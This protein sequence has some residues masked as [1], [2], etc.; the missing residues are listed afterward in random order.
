MSEEDAVVDPASASET[1][2]LLRAAESGPSPA[3]GNGTFRNKPAASPAVRE[4]GAGSGG[5]AEAGSPQ[6]A[7]A[8]SRQGLPEVAKQLPILIPAVGIGVFLCA[9]DQLLAVATYAKIGSE[10]DALNSTSWIATAYFLTLTSF[11]PLY[12]KLSDI[13]GRKACLL[14]SYVVFTIGTLGCGLAPNMSFL[15][16]ARA[17]G[18][19][20]GGGMNALVSILLTDIVPMRDRG[21]W[22]GFIN[23]IFAL[24]TS[25]GAPLGG[26]LADSVGWRWSFLGQV[27]FCVLAFI[28]VY[29][30]LHLPSG[31]STHWREKLGRVDFLGAGVLVAAVLCLLFGLDNGSNA[32]W[33][34]KATIVPLAVAPALFALFVWV[35]A[36]VAT[37]PFAPGRIVFARGLAPAYISNF[38]MMGGQMQVLFFLPLLYQA[39]DGFSAVRA[40]VFL[41]P[42]S[43]MGVTAS[44]SAGFV[45]RATGR[46]YV[47]TIASLVLLVLSLIPLEI[48]VGTIAS[49]PRM[50]W[51]SAVGMSVAA[52]GVGSAITTTLMAIISNAAHEDMA[53]AVAVSYLFRSLGSAVGVAVGSA[54]M[55]QILRTQLAVRLEDGNEAARIEERVRQSLDYINELEPSVAAIVRRCYE[56]GIVGVFACAGIFMA[57][58]LLSSIWLREK[59][60]AR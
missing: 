45:M 25:T 41:I 58:C 54:V 40:G 48:S 3:N 12:G 14:F 1:T 6:D 10:L 56:V 21:V 53:V 11:Q 7:A 4:N 44:V 19:I 47:L 35:E 30:A 17:I 42:G 32:G 38:M 5:D 51:L 49:V 55:Q 24:G 13:F 33:A 18:G 9:L 27:P 29:F 22:Q 26:L 57:L 2:A 43:V 8:V 59:K 50:P 39:V 23:I 46:Y 60:I 20:G 28:A 31:D 36:R 34:T 15:I 52:L 37:H 16:I